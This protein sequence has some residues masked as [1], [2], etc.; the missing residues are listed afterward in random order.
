MTQIK[1]ILILLMATLVMTEVA[2]EA[3]R[4]AILNQADEKA[5]N[6]WVNAT[7]SKMTPDEKIAQLMVAAVFPQDNDETRE[8]VNKLVGQYKVG[9]LI[10]QES[11]IK[12]QVSC[13]NY[14]QSITQVPLM[15]TL[16]A[17]W[18]LS[19][20]LE[21]APK[22]PRN[23]YLGAINNDKLFYDYGREIARQCKRIGVNVDFAPVLDVI[24]RPNTVIGDR[25]YGYNPDVVARHGIAF[26][27]GLEDGGVLSVGKH[28]PG[29]GCTT[30]DSHK[31][32]PTIDKSMKELNIDDLMPFRQYINAGLSGMLTGHIY[33]PAIDKRKI[34][35]TMSDKV[36]NGLLKKRMGFEGLIFTDA[37]NMGGAK[38]DGSVCV[39][40]LLAGNDVLL[41][42]VNVGTEIEAI[43]KA[44]ADGTLKQSIID[45]RCKKI[46]RFKYALGLNTPQ[47]V[48]MNNVV[49]DVNAPSATLMARR[50]TAG[51]ITVVKNDGNVLPV[52][53]LQSQRIAVL[54]MGV[55][56]DTKSMFQ[57]R[58]ASYAATTPFDYRA[59]FSSRDSIERALSAGRFNNIIIAIKADDAA[60]RTFAQSIAK[61]FRNVTVAIFCDPQK[62][63]KY[64]SLM[65]SDDVD[66]VVVA[67][68][69]TTVAEDYAAQTIFGGNAADGI[70]PVPVKDKATGRKFDAGTGIR[71]AATRLGYTLPEEVGFDHNLLQK[72]DSICK[73]G[74]AQHAF[75]GCQVLVARHGKVVCNRAY[76]EID[77]G[78]GIP[79]TTNTLFGLASVSKAT[80]TEC[81]VMKVY[82][83]GKFS[84]DD[85]ASTFIPGLQGT[86][87]E[88]I[89]FRDLL[90]H[91]T[92]MPPSLNMWNMMFDPNTYTGQ[93]ITSTQ[94]EHNTVKVMDGAYGNKS[95]KL[96]TDILSTTKTSEFNIPIAEGIYGG[97]VT[98]D[99]IMNR[100]Y[101]QPLG[102]KRYLYSCLNFCLLANAV[103]NITHMALNNFTNN[104]VFAPLGAY[105]TTYRPLEKFPSSQIAYTEMDTYLRRQHIHGYV[106]D[107]LAAFSGG[108]QGNA[109][110]FSNAN[111]LAK[112]LQLWLNGGT[113]GGQRIY[114]ESTVK[115][116]TT[117]KSPN[118]HRGLGFDKPNMSNP[119]WSSTCDEATAETYGHTGFTGTC[120]WVDPKNDMI[121]IF[122]CNRVSPTR[123]N[124][125]FSRVSARSHIQSLLYHSIVK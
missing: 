58:C 102:N 67:Y 115:T 65:V 111:D 44:V 31:S 73:Y 47:H 109:G 84:L 71:Y 68:E 33:V 3:K 116:F 5:M 30:V 64:S 99:S 110:L 87:K 2:V 4:P 121:Y 66:A 86:N 19:M 13:T 55:D 104:Y 62:L 57:R 83:D 11:E 45:E 80:G 50:L 43:K 25:G 76:G 81:A 35:G 54:T 89:T 6:E 69:R 49:E 36:V 82:D 103:Q 119:S 22:Y 48:D 92:G 8:A 24:D 16:D 12:K 9:G 40:A 113:Y 37:L 74:I 41:M 21:N 1:R 98:Y 79:V 95:A 39:S 51:T 107:E 14:A 72:I 101:N 29:H 90:Y 122:L 108:V 42:P 10:Y 77:Y 23:L 52:G 96:R 88:D 78:T 59:N 91:E 85:K 106:H 125:A 26:S 123:N 34:P 7:F 17:E 93:L 94:T 20:R 32:L 112:L 15:I 114:K 70:L 120:F 27:K 124:P 38:V 18:G 60:Y 28:F 61:K 97:K 100:I 63:D 105:H 75:P 53:N 46:L 118:S 117:E 56:N